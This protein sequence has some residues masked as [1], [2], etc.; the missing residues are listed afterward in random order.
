MAFGKSDLSYPSLSCFDSATVLRFHRFHLLLFG[1]A[2]LGAVQPKRYLTEC[3]KV[4]KS[5]VDNLFR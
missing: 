1:Q 2:A 4:L 3:R 5:K